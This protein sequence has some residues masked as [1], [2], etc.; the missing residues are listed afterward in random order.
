[1]NVV[2]MRTTIFESYERDQKPGLLMS[3]DHTITIMVR[4]TVAGNACGSATR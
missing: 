3:L 4:E 2:H 1:M